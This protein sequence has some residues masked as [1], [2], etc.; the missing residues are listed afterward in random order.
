M[1]VCECYHYYKG[2][3]MK[4]LHIYDA[5]EKGKGAKQSEGTGFVALLVM[6]IIGLI[7]TFAPVID[8]GMDFIL[9]MLGIK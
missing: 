6:I 8:S 4:N 5:Y 2:V 9:D 3:I 7:M 1:Y